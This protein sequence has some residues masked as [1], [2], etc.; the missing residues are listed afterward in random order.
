MS[1]T[2]TYNKEHNFMLTRLADSVNDE[3]VFDHVRALNRE[4]SDKIHVKELADC[5][6]LTD[7]HI[8]TDGTVFNATQED[9]KLGSNLAI[10]VPEGSSYIFSLARAYQMFSKEFR[11]SVMVFRNPDEAM[12]WLTNHNPEE[13]AALNRFMADVQEN[14]ILNC[15]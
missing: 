8:T 9:I 2:R 3:E 4:L 13:T 1:I 7:V 6:D 12:A 14:E 11:N 5:R 15:V 10:L